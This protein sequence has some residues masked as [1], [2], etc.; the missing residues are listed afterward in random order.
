MQAI[1]TALDFRASGSRTGCMQAIEKAQYVPRVKA[2]RTRF[3]FGRKK[4][5]PGVEHVAA[6]AEHG[7]PVHVEGSADIGAA[8]A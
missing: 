1:E 8:L 4:G 2:A 5:F 7:A 6:M 3:W